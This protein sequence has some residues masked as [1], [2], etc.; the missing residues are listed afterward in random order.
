MVGNDKKSTDGG[1][2]EYVDGKN[3]L[4]FDDVGRQEGSAGFDRAQQHTEKQA[5]GVMQHSNNREE[6]R[7]G[8]SPNMSFL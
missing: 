1:E 8:R 7:F 4:R 2:N 6:A 5:R 3:Q